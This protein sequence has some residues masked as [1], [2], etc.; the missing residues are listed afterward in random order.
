MLEGA[1]LG[2]G[3]Y[4]GASLGLMIELIAGPL[5]DEFLSFEAKQDDAG[6]GGSPKGGELLL[7]IDPAK[8]GAPDNFLDHDEKLFTAISEQEGTRLPGQRRLIGRAKTE[9]DGIEVP[10]SLHETILTLMQNRTVWHCI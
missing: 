7:A 6:R 5:I 1:Q 2:F 9:Q 4:K 8:F 10:Q 3:G